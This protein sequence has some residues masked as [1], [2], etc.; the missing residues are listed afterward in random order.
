MSCSLAAAHVLGVVAHGEQAGVEL[1]MQRLDAAVHD[2]REAG[3][4]VDGAD[5]EAGALELLRGA[6]RGDDLDAELG[7]AGGEVDDPALVGD[8]QQRAA[9]PDCSRL[10]EWLP[11]PGGG[12]LG[13]ARSIGEARVSERPRGGTPDATPPSPHRR[14]GMEQRTTTDPERELERTGDELEERIDDLDDH[15]DEARQEAQG[16]PRGVRPVEE[17]AAGDWE[18]TDDDAGG[19]DAERL[20]RSRGR[21]GRRRGLGARLLVHHAPG[22]GGRGRGAAAPPRSGRP[23]AAAARARSGAGAAWT[24]AGIARVGQLDRALQDDRARCRPPRRRGGPS[25]RRPS[26][27]SR[28]PARSRARRGR[29]AAARGGR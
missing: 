2:L 25:R 24:A 23:P 3:E 14:R 10:R 12:V 26:R 27:R 28:A 18:D 6:A 9:D 29:R 7:E 15:I 11:R 19:E 21:R 17:D 13:D 8:G 1:G 20:R 5:R 4:V 16:A 22:A